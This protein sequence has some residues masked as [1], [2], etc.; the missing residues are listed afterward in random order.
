MPVVYAFG[1]NGSGQLGI[2]H[3]RDVVRP[4]R[5][6]F[7]FQQQRRRQSRSGDRTK[8]SESDPDSRPDSDGIGHG[9]GSSNSEALPVTAQAPIVKK[10]VAGGNHS[11]VLTTDGR[12]FVAGKSGLTSDDPGAGRES[13]S[14]AVFEEVTRHILSSSAA[15]SDTGG[16]CNGVITDVAATWD[17]SFAV[18]GSKI[19][20]G[21]GTGTKGELGLGPKM[22]STGGQVRKIFDVGSVTSRSEAV[23]IIDIVGSL[24]HVVVLLASGEVYGWGSCRKGQLG[25]QFKAE[26]I[27]WSPRNIGLGIH[28]ENLLPWVPEKV[29]LGREYTVFIKAGKE[30]A[31]WGDTRVFDGRGPGLIS[32]ADDV[33]TSGW[34]SI[35]ILS[36]ARPDQLQSAGRNNHGQLPPSTLPAVKNV[37]A[38]S[39]HCVALTMDN[40]VIAWGWG[41]HGN[42]GETLDNRGNVIDRYNLIPLPTPDEDIVAENV[43]AGCA[44]SFVVCGM[45]DG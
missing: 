32:Q 39:E 27:L 4:E 24:A 14:N 36:R 29:V 1:S 28:G 38:G 12:L 30:P 2:G 6:L 5:C 37:A 9:D 31:T 40:Q 22:T 21:W 7:S 26:K 10:I 33:V 41:E 42:C 43:A 25:E 45:K 15:S 18:L 35:H 23:D 17:A 44:T 16:R 11:L 3:T 13:T 8:L 20:V 19:I 34:S